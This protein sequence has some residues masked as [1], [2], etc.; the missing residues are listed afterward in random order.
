MRH[1]AA[2]LL[3]LPFSSL[4]VPTP[5][6]LN[7]FNKSLKE[8]DGPSLSNFCLDLG[9]E[10]LAS[11]WNKRAGLL[12]ARHFV[13]SPRYTCT[14]LPAV[15]KAFAI[16]LATLRQQYQTS[17]R[18][19]NDESDAETALKKSLDKSLKA[20]R[21]RRRSVCGVSNSNTFLLIFFYTY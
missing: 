15:V 16:H 8:R 20:R 6:Q 9:S 1:L 7:T 11:Q 2:E 14:D 18:L 3:D 21:N 5:A 13:A 19:E 17:E 4:R 10:G 12:F